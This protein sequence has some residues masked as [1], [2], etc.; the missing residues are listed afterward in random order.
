MDTIT[1]TVPPERIG[2]LLGKDGK[3]KAL[4]EEKSGTTIKVNGQTGAVEIYSKEDDTYKVYRTSQVIQAIAKGFSPEHAL[5]LLNDEYSL[6][7]IDMSEWYNDKKDVRRQASRIIGREG[8][9]RK[10]LETE[11][12]C[13]ISVYEHYVSII[14]KIE[15]TPNAQEAVEMILRGI[16]QKIVYGVLEKEKQKE[17]FRE[18]K[19]EV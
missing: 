14:G 17:S 6:I 16:P 10:T 7:I 11:T 8:K 3:G 4:I 2:A 5:L 15:N 13:L 9:T 12:K 18:R 19:V 1:E